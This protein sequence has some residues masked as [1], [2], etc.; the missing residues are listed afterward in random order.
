MRCGGTGLSNRSLSAVCPDRISA[1]CAVAVILGATLLISPVEVLAQRGGG[2][3]GM[4][5]TGS[6]GSRPIIC[7]HDCRDLSSKVNL[8]NQDLKNFEHI[9][10][11]QA[12]AEQ[13]A[14]FESVLQDRQLAT[15]ELKAFREGQAKLLRVPQPDSVATFDDAV[16]TARTETQKF[17][18]S[19]S[20]TQKSEL[21][22]IIKKLTD[23]NSELDQEVKALD[24]AVRLPSANNDNV[25]VVTANLEK[26]LGNF[27]SE[28]LALGQQMSILPA[29]DQDLTFHFPQVTSTVEIGGQPISVAAGGAATRTSNADG[30]NLFSLELLADLSDL[31]GKI[32]D[33][34]RS[35]LNRTPRCGE[36]IEVQQALLF[37]RPAASLAV[38][39]LHRERWICPPGV[40][41][42]QLVAD[43]NATSE[44]KFSPFIGPDGG[45]HLASE[46]SHV[47]AIGLLRDSLI[48]GTL[49]TEFSQQINE[50]LLSAAR[51]AM[52]LKATLPSTAQNA[53]T[54]N[55]AQFEDEGS[56]QLSLVLYGQLQFSDEQIK[57]F[58][59][60]LKQSLTAQAT[61][62]QP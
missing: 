46:I 29:P 62:Q 8:T 10:A 40:N 28:Q 18:T 53:V 41:S 32:T 13:K 22:D 6:T 19:F 44:F 36:R 60:E 20:A 9:M 52:D 25:A 4:G 15:Q 21:K 59:A 17:L 51:K 58:A 42:E 54:I 57:Q 24:E 14:A 56:N 1:S 16:E 50:S 61:S 49:G 2:G 55:K 39:H 43:S 27:E 33:I 48:S 35:Q 5:S 37:P 31:Q 38:V 3:R 45:L 26:A 30:R 7:V 12:T 47:E 34:L 11:V 23:T